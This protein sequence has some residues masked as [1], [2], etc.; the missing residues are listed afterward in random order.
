[1]TKSDSDEFLLSNWQARQMLTRL[2]PAFNQ[3]ALFVA[4]PETT[5]ENAHSERLHNRKHGIKAL[6]G[7][8]ERYRARVSLQLNVKVCAD[9]VRDFCTA[10]ALVAD[11]RPQTTEEDMLFLQRV[12]HMGQ[13]TQACGTYLSNCLGVIKGSE[14]KLRHPEGPVF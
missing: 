14:K 4:A 6:S 3:I 1:M 2:T 8:I 9:I 11:F 5:I 12:L 7:F 10:R 13:R